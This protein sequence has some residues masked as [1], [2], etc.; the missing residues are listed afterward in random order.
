MKSNVRLLEARPGD[1]T[2]S[3]EALIGF[4]KEHSAAA[5]VLSYTE[6]QFIL[7]SMRRPGSQK[8]VWGQIG[9]WL[10]VFGAAKRS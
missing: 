3:L 7:R 5:T 9:F 1:G 8:R 10:C 2:G 4:C 6:A